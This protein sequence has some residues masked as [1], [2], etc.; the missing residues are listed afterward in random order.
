MEELNDTPL[1]LFNVNSSFD[2]LITPS[3]PYI[4]YGDN[5]PVL[6]PT[7]A[8][9]LSSSSSHNQLSILQRPTSPTLHQP[10]SINPSL[11]TSHESY[12]P[13]NNAPPTPTLNVL[14]VEFLGT[15]SPMTRSATEITP[16]L[17]IP[18]KKRRQEKVSLVPLL[19]VLFQLTERRTQTKKRTQQSGKSMPFRLTSMSCMIA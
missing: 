10:H 1:T 15:S 9:S 17:S 18:T 11:Q 7:S 14:P 12:P 8:Q 16:L 13:N 4:T 2:D 3:S 6:H 19:L 5:S